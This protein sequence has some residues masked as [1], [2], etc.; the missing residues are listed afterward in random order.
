MREPF[1]AACPF[2]KC[3]VLGACWSGAGPLQSHGP[4]GPLSWAE[5]AAGWFGARE[6]GGD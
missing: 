2:R 1:A 3:E 6:W 5:K 4:H